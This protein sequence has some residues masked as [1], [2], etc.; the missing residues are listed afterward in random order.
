MVIMAEEVKT[1]RNKKN[2]AVGII[3]TILSVVGLITIISS[4]ISSIS[5][6]FDKS[7]KID[8]YKRYLTPIV[9]ND[10]NPFDDVINADQ[11]Q[12]ISMAIWSLLSSDIDPDSFKYT[13]G[14]M[15]IGIDLVEEEFVKLFG[16]D[17]APL[18]QTVDGGEGIQFEYD[19]EEKAYL[20]PITGI[21]ALYSPMIAGISEKGSSTI[22]TVGYLAQ[23]DWKIDSNGN[24]VAPEPVKY[25]NIYLR[26]N[27]DGYYISSIKQT[28]SPEVVTTKPTTEETSSEKGEN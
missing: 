28:D 3:I 6:M 2:L 12:L 7:D 26:K 21:S 8:E 20:V 15:L 23:E 14:G 25:M 11:G 4:C 24:M 10:P 13:D 19:K 18:H 22:L 9:M 17:V 27:G 5:N 1:R 16:K